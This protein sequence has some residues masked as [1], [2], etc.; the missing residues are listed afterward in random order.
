M[1]LP[2]HGANAHYLY[3][4]LQIDQPERTIDFSANLNPL[5]PPPSLKEKWEDAFELITTY[6]DPHAANLM[7]KLA[8]H[9]D[10]EENQLLIGNGGAELITLVGRY[11]AGKRVCIVQPTFSEYESA[12]LRAGCD[13]TYHTLN[14]NEWV[15][16][17][18]L[19]EKFPYV[20]AVFLCTPN[21]PTGVTYDPASVLALVEAA[22]KHDCAIIIDEAFADFL[23]DESSFSSLLA[24]FSNLM[25]LRSLTKMYAIP[26][27]RLGYMM[28]HPEVIEAIKKLQPH[29]SVNALALHA[30][31]LCLQETDFVAET[32]Q[33]IEQERE[34]CF[35]FFE[36]NNYIYSNSSVNFYLLRDPEIEDQSELLSFLMK[37]GIVPRHTENFPGLDG[38]WLRFAIRTPEENERLREVLTSWR[39]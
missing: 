33:V 12:C 20:D 7:T 25:I 35:H 24:P 17:S 15:L 32:H 30:G 38:R 21:N 14:E 29:W 23:G 11:L 5:G 39:S 28:A 26:G 1:T 18:H 31:E 16:G 10:V 3:E 6:P 4:A 9:H 19:I 36:E 27:L 37:K 13:V 34:K 8:N 2:S 22:K